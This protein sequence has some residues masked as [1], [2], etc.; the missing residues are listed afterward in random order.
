MFVGIFF[1]GKTDINCLFLNVQMIQINK[2]EFKHTKIM[3]LLKFIASWHFLLIT[4]GKINIIWENIFFLK[5]FSCFQC[6]GIYFWAGD[7]TSN[8]L[9]ITNGNTL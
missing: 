7:R 9:G 5:D 8:A 1:C 6:L 3:F 4:I 2:N